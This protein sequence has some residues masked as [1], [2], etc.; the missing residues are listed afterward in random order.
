MTVANSVNC[1]SKFT[2]LDGNRHRARL[3]DEAF[4]LC[5]CECCSIGESSPGNVGDCEEIYRFF[6]S[7]GDVDERTNQV[8]TTAFEKAAQNGLSVF[9]GCAQDEDIK[10]LVQDMLTVKPGRP[11]RTVLGLLKAVVR[12]IRT[13]QGGVGG[14][15]FCVYDETVPRKMDRSLPHV[16][17]HVSIYQRVPA[18]GEKDRNKV[19]ESDNYKLYS[20]LVLRRIG[21]ADFRGGLLLELN[22]RSLAGEF[23]D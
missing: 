9:R 3:I 20:L 11:Y 17:T 6:V 22:K 21:I 2:T 15:A 8:F 7:P 13:I 16:P 4:P 14:R 18:S 5:A 12:D 23:V 1:K 19:I 10:C